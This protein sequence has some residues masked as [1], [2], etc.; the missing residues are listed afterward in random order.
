MK[1]T[2][3]LFLLALLAAP[4]WGQKASDYRA[5]AE[6][7]D[8]VAQY[9][10]GI[11]YDM[12][13]D[14]K[15]AVY[16]YTKAANQGYAEAQFILGVC[17]DNGDGVAEDDKQAVYWFTKAANQRHAWAQFYLGFCYFRGEGVAQDYKQAVYWYTKAANQGHAT[18]Q[19]YLGVF[20]YYGEGVAK[21]CHQALNWLK[22]AKA[23][24]NGLS[25]SE[26]SSVGNF[27]LAAEECAKTQAPA[28]TPQS[29]STTS[30]TGT[31]SSS[32]PQPKQVS[33][34][35]LYSRG[36]AYFNGDGVEH[37]PEKAVELWTQSAEKGY[38]TAQLMLA[39]CY[40][41]G[42][43]AKKDLRKAFEWYSKAAS[44]GNANAQGEV[45]L[46]YFHG[47]GVQADLSKAEMW[48][49]K[50]WAQRSKMHD[51][52]RGDV[53]RLIKTDLP[54][55]KKQQSA[56]RQ[57][58]STNKNQTGGN[59][60][61][62]PRAISDDPST[63]ADQ[64]EL[65]TRYHHGTAGKRKDT[66]KAIHWYTRAANQGSPEAM[67][68]LGR[69]YYY[70]SSVDKDPDE[71]LYWLQKIEFRQQKLQSTHSGL[72]KEAMELLGR[73]RQGK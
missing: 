24:E 37:S 62:K 7:G 71:A 50:A 41:D 51:V 1:K 66:K 6:R 21:D 53:E 14:Y 28:A 9:N 38:T 72:V 18:A 30:S 26:Q 33:A 3:I 8:K 44:G 34:A 42:I 15:Q 39:E 32:T 4:L 47:N 49:K 63:A 73:I 69:I 61:A 16:W 70:G 29:R 46:A 58:S 55:R 43:G 64:Y 56:S 52:L 22:K 12:A 31:T 45:A 35:E 23:A 17:Y 48:A 60:Q 36:E 57:S 19:Y 2:L 20:Y 10:L 65:A 11:C 59:T 27:L 5:A 67:L 54:A 68:E 40:K 13:Y 25:T